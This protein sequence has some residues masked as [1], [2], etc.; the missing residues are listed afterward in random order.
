MPNLIDGLVD[1]INTKIQDTITGQITIFPPTGKRVIENSEQISNDIGELEGVEGV[2]ETRNVATRLSY[3]DKTL[4]TNTFVIDPVN[5]QNVFELDK[6]L[7]EGRLLDSDSTEEIVL[8]AEIAGRKDSPEGELRE[9]RNSLG[10]VFVGDNVIVNIN[11]IDKEF[12]V[13]GIFDA[14]FPEVDSNSYISANSYISVSPQ[15]IGQPT[16]INIA[17]NENV[18][19]IISEIESLEYEFEIL[20]WKDIGGVLESTTESFEIL[21]LILQV[22]SLIIGAITIFIVTYVDLTNKRRHIGIQRAIGITNTSI[23]IGFVLRSLFSSILAIGLGAIL[24]I[25]VVVPVEHTYP[26]EFPFGPAYLQIDRQYM[27]ASGIILLIVTI[28][29]SAVPTIQTLKIKI[30]DSIWG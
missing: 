7:I 19:K 3:K 21:A 26:L 14:E 1:T 4:N 15:P 10:E 27:I 30:L 24:Y 25:F 9:K 13:I 11:G 18:D 8:G 6:Y 22:I 12:E 29:S 2:T 17:T 23:F 28:V 16:T 5:Y 20:S